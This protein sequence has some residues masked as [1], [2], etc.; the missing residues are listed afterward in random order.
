MPIDYVALF[1]ALENGVVD[2]AKKSLSDY[3]KD[4]ISDGMNIISKMKANIE[5]WTASLANGE[6][7][8]D[9][10]KSLLLGQQDLL[11]MDALVQA[12]LTLI[13][14]DQFKNAV[15]DL[16]VDTVTAIL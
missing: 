3:L 1:N 10:F 7:D 11:K 8:A 2:L 4:G 12:G 16:I 6:I 15:G 5:I 14:I 9:D 13:R